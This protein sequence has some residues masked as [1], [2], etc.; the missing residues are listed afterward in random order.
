ML[1]YFTKDELIE[2]T[3]FSLSVVYSFGDVTVF[4]RQRKGNVFLEE[5]LIKRQKHY[6]KNE[7]NECRK[8]ATTSK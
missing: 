2:A 8:A 7:V 6:R 4:T 3:L 1:D 5:E